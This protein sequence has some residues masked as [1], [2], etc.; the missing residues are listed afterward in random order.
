MKPRPILHLLSIFSIFIPLLCST[1]SPS[2]TFWPNPFVFFFANSTAGI[3]ERG[4]TTRFS[5]NSE[6]NR[7]F[8][9]SDYSEIVYNLAV[10]CDI[11]LGRIGRNWRRRKFSPNCAQTAI[12]SNSLRPN[13]NNSQFSVHAVISFPPSLRLFVLFVSFSHIRIS[14]NALGH[15]CMREES[16]L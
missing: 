16:F 12:Y 7:N 1:Y 14:L 15:F 10:I 2:C 8:I 13:H 9:T 11:Y 5:A 6:H 3:S 4:K